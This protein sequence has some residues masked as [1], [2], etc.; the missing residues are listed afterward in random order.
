MKSRHTYIHSQGF[1]L[2]ELMVVLVLMGIILSMMTLTV[3]DGGKYRQLEEESLR[4]K[5]LMNMAK[6]EVIIYSQEWFI[7]FKDDG[8]LFEQ[9][10]ITLK[11]DVDDSDQDGDGK[12]PDTVETKKKKTIPIE[13][14]IFR[15]RQLEGYHLSVVIEGEE[16][17][18]S[19]DSD[20]DEEEEG[21]IGRIPIHSTGEMIEFELK[22][23]QEDEDDYFVLKGTENGDLSL[24]SSRD[25][26]I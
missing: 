22:I 7:V 18:F 2:M 21:T 13:N 23:Q 26:E 20:D 1:T 9:E 10:K 4:L 8:Y 25:D 15:S 3:G 5:T 12:K 17:S 14:K 11:T 19:L 6:E 24:K 16:H